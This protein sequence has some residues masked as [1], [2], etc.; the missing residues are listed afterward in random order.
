[1]GLIL[2]LERFPGG[3]CGKPPQ[4]SC[5]ENPMDRGAWW[6]AVHRVAKSWMTEGTE[7]TRSTKYKWSRITL[8]V[9]MIPA[10]MWNYLAAHMER[11]SRAHWVLSSLSSTHEPPHR[12][13]VLCLTLPE[14]GERG[15]DQP[16]LVL[17]GL[18]GMKASS[19]GV[20][21]AGSCDEQTLNQATQVGLS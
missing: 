12:E 21:L 19:S 2:G 4:Y 6:A 17:A 11:M 1:M 3:A 7:Y 20:L 15:R 5:L 9:E 10:R 16:Q 13:E 8:L 14:P 18:S